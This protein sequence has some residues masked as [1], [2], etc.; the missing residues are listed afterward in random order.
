MMWLDGNKN[1]QGTTR[2]NR[3][4]KSTKDK[5]IDNE[6]GT[7]RIGEIGNCIGV[8]ELNN[9]DSIHFYNN[10]TMYYFNEEGLF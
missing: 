4:V 1:P 8:I 5:R 2:E 7:Q 9:N 3:N 6:K 10:G